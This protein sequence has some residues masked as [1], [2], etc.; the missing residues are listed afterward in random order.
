MTLLSRLDLNTMAVNL[1]RENGEDAFS[2]IDIFSIINNQKDST[3]VL[4]PMSERISGMCTKEGKNVLIGINSKL[5]YGRQ[6]F[7]IAH[8]FYH[9][10]F[11]KGFKR[12]IC[13]TSLQVKK[14]DE[15]KNADIFASYLLAPDEALKSYIHR[16][17]QKDHLS[18]VDIVQTEQFFQ[19]SRF[20]LLIRLYEDGFINSDEIAEF[21][22]GVIQSALDLGFD[23]KLYR[24][25]PSDKQYYTTGNYIKL[26]KKVNE[27]ELVSSG[28]Y[29]SILL[30]AF[31]ADIVYNLASEGED[32]YE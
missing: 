30:D 3:L 16:T 17:F 13:E 15:E 29:E 11:Q 20:A 12:V 25:S 7:S 8:E 26:A 9:L 5:T 2:P 10:F 19:I 14:D 32:V 27:H 4:L 1:R 21:R 31:R 18:L 6:R 23:D 24:P 22:K 28:K